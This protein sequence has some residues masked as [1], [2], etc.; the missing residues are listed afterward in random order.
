L[1]DAIKPIMDALDDIR[2]SP[3]NKADK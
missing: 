2:R 1:Q 3:A